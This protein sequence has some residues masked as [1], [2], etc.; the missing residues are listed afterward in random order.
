M[1]NSQNTCEMG[2]A[3]DSLFIEKDNDFKLAD[4]LFTPNLKNENQI[5][6]FKVGNR[7][8]LCIETR[9]NLYFDKVDNLEVKSGSK[10]MFQKSIKQ[11]QKNK[12][13]A[14]YVM[15]VYKNY[16][17]TLKD[18]GI[19]SYVFNNAETFFGKQDIKEV[20]KIANCFYQTI[21]VSHTK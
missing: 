8:Y 11:H 16:I 19:T 1:S 9:T 6:L 13:T 10:S 17:A 15:E 4:G 18:E 14:F 20:K 7:Y 2:F 12:H 5:K 21:N 3:T